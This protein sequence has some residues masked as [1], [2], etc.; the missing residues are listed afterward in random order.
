[1]TYPRVAENQWVFPVH[2]NYRL[3][4]C[5]CGLVHVANFRIVRT[6]QGTTPGTFRIRQVLLAKHLRVAFQM[7]RDNRATAAKRRQR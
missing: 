4:C 2:D 6:G 5:D 1:M 3:A 7:R